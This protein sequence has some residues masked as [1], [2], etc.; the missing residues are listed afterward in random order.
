MK[1]RNTSTRATESKPE[2]RSKE[3]GGAAAAS[4]AQKKAKV[5][6]PNSFVSMVVAVCVGFAAVLVGTVHVMKRAR[7]AARARGPIAED[8]PTWVISER[9][10]LM[11]VAGLLT[12]LLLGSSMTTVASRLKEQW[13][14]RRQA[15]LESAAIKKAAQE[16]AAFREMDKAARTHRTATFLMKE[17]CERERQ[18][19]FEESL[20]AELA[21]TRRREAEATAQAAR[22][23]AQEVEQAQQEA[24]LV[25]E[26]IRLATMAQ[27]E[28]SDEWDVGEYS[29]E[30][31]GAEEGDGGEWGVDGEGGDAEEEGAGEEGGEDGTHA[32][33]MP[34]EHRPAAR[35]TRVSLEALVIPPGASARVDAMWVELRCLRCSERTELVISGLYADASAKKSWCGKCAALISSALRPSLL[36]DSSNVAGYIDTGGCVVADVPRLNVLM[37]CA[38]CDAERHLPELIRGRTVQEGCRECHAPLSL[39]MA[40]VQLTQLGASADCMARRA[41]DNNDDDE[42]EQLL[43]KLRKKNIDQFK[44]MGLVIGKPLPN[45]GAC[46]H[47]SHSYRWLRFPCCGRAHP[48]AVCHAASDCPAAE[49]GVW[50]TRMLCGKCSR[51][52]PY[53]DSPCPHCGNTFTK[54]GG[55]HWQGG[56]GCRDQ[57]SLSHGDSRKHKGMS[58]T[59]VKKT[60]S[61]KSSRVGVQGKRATA[62]KAAARGTPE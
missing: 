13:K 5:K 47:Y 31:D 52:L 15:A 58:A 18:A 45:K 28:D 23:R 21:E 6:K 7:R 40:N 22:A 38:R 3:K 1:A 30:G 41:A 33:R 50:A 9:A 34:L 24:R 44:V 27:A 35:G 56:A 20:R 55:A 8:P 2:G 60:S 32:E 16:K 43:K 49:Q 4:G 19:A 25:D 36:C 12:I 39:R 53:S 42:M 61:A 62:A 54:P 26:R 17:D 51:E 46:R 29:L 37:A 11:A 59:G 10:L 48:C 14:Q 57:Q